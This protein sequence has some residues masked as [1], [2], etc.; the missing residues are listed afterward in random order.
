[1]RL[2]SLLLRSSPWPPGRGVHAAFAIGE[3]E[4]LQ[5]EQAF[6]YTATA[7]RIE[8]DRRVA[9]DAGLLPLQEAHG[10]RRRRR[11]A[12]RWA[13]SV[14]PKGEI[15][16]DEY[17]GEQEVFRGTFKVTAPLSGAKAG[18]TMALKLK[19]QGCADAGLCYPPSVWDASVKVAAAAHQVTADKI[20]A[21]RAKRAAPRA[22]KNFSIPTWPS[23]SR[24][25]AQS[26][27]NVQLNWRI[28][29]GYYL[30]KQRIKLEPADAA[31]PVGALVLPK[32]EPHSRRILR[33]AGSVSRR[34]S[35]RR[36]R[37]R[38]R[39]EDRRREGD[40]PGLRR[41]GPVLSAASPRHCRSR[42]KARRRRCVTSAADCATA[43][44]MSRS[45]TASPTQSA[46]ATAPWLASS[47]SART[48]A[49]VHALRAADGADPLRN[50]RGRRRERLARPRVL[51]V[52]GLCAGHGR[53]RTRRRASLRRARQRLNLQAIFNQPWIIIAVCGAVR[54]AG[55]FDVRL[56][57][58]P[59]AGFIQSR[60]AT[61]ATSSRPARSS[62]SAVMG[63]LSA[64]IVTA[65]VAPA[66]VAALSVIGQSGRSRAAALALFAMASAWA[67]PCWWSAPRPGSCC[68]APARGWIR[69]STLFGVLFL[70]GGRLDAVRAS[71]PSGSACCCGSCPRSPGQG[72]VARGVTSRAAARDWCAALAAL[73]AVYGAA[74]A[75]RR[76]HW[77]RPIRWRRFRSCAGAAEATLGSSA[78]SRSPISSAKWRRPRPA[79]K[80]VMLD[81]YAD[82]C[83][84]C[85]EMEHYTFTDPE[86]RA[87][88]A[89]HGAAAGRCHGERRRTTRRCCSTSASLARRPSPSMA[90]T[91]PNGET[92]ASSV[93]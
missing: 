31:R 19:W 41:R 62:A 35:T 4:F 67:C 23:C 46:A 54:R 43:R 15:Q 3:D 34:V 59:D 74:V 91:A 56:V 51:A 12:S 52:G 88:L 50:H 39:R 60:L 8:G 58:R 10:S 29:D 49:G 83:V 61:R 66:L 27:N 57:H 14:Y 20:F 26:A 80:S 30:Y 71:C 90:P 65:C 48:A 28:A 37:Y 42:S 69:S 89:Q 6:K 55:D 25:T 17:F 86:V 38:L 68:R 64:L 44:S 47:S 76:A 78:S 36:S 87:A 9:G 24:R 93:S 72:A 53:A 81:F 85:K 11:P 79:G 32:G 40:L 13:K 16:K 75:G 92:S 21:E 1:M 82:W 45:R 70:G 84:S 22:T 77:A 7:D 33:R 18:D 2:K 63:A 5:P 73:A